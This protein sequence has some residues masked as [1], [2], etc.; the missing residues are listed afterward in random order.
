MWHLRTEL[1]T[2]S[3]FC[4]IHLSISGF[5]S[6]RN[7]NEQSKLSTPH[8]HADSVND[9]VLGQKL[10]VLKQKDAIHN[11]VVIVS[12]CVSA[13]SIY[14]LHS[15]TPKSTGGDAGRGVFDPEAAV[16]HLSRQGRVG[17]EAGDQEI[18]DGAD[19]GGGFA[20]F[21][22][23]DMHRDGR[24]FGVFQDEFERAGP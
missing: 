13:F 24:R 21:L 20:G 19:A 22:V 10:T 1:G 14:V 6:A 17:T 8:T 7:R 3:G 23:Q 12:S 15:I 2:L 4:L 18:D 16:R 9:Q 11:P 5:E